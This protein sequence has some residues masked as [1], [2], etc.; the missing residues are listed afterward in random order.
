M[1]NTDLNGKSEIKLKVLLK[2]KL[3]FNT[4]IVVPLEEQLNHWRKNDFQK[5]NVEY[6]LGDLQNKDKSIFQVCLIKIKGEDLDLGIKALL[7]GV[8]IIT[9]F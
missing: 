7:H 5:I 3:F 8:T 1:G 2:S 9:K 6:P 4:I